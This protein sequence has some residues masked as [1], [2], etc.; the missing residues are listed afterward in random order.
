MRQ[1]RIVENRTRR[2]KAV[3]RRAM[4]EMA[5]EIVEEMV[6]SRGHDGRYKV[7]H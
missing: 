7:R 2:Q 4:E 3:V 6:D 1:R 5:E